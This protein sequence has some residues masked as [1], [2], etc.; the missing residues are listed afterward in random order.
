MPAESIKISQ[1]ELDIFE[2]KGI[3]KEGKPFQMLTFSFVDPI[4]GKTIT[5]KPRYYQDSILLEMCYLRGFS[6]PPADPYNK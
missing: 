4:S 5:M 2:T 6:A 1:V 3:S